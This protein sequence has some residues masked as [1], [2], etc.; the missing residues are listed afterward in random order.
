MTMKPRNEWRRVV[1]RVAIAALVGTLIGACSDKPQ[2]ESETHFLG[3]CEAGC[4]SGLSC[5]CGVCSVPCTAP[6]ACTALLAKA[7]CETSPAACEDR[8]RACDLACTQKSQCAD[9][10]GDFACVEGRCRK[11][12]PLASEDDGSTLA[13]PDDGAVGA[14][15][16][17]AE[18]ASPAVQRDAQARDAAL[19]DSASSF[20]ANN[21]SD[22]TAKAE[23]GAGEAGTCS[24]VGAPCCDPFPRDGANYCLRGLV[25]TRGSCQVDCGCVRGAFTPVCGVDGQTHDATCG[26]SCVPVAIACEG[27]CPC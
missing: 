16:G 27:Q 14:L 22:A 18:D 19:T 25:C 7:S 3:D 13:P 21:A 1:G 9:L 20:D 11:A 10:G 8:G 23:T 5:I 4:G 17:G 2:V 12:E 15:D 26:R 6:A 24:E